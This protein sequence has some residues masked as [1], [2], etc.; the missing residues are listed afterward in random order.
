MAT[1]DIEGVIAQYEGLVT[2]RDA[3]QQ[4]KA[5]LDAEFSARKRVLK[6]VM[7]E[8]REA[9]YDPDK[10][11]EELQRTEE[12]VRIKMEVF[13]TELEEGENIIRPMLKE[14]REAG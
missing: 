8:T 3:L 14:I 5:K 10:I 13:K 1:T 11:K 2:R 7:D 4:N 9:G 12:V 6:K